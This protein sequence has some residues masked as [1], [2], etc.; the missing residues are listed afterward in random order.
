MQHQ[1]NFLNESFAQAQNRIKLLQGH[2]NYLKDSDEEKC[3]EPAAPTEQPS[4][5]PGYDSCRCNR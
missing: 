1:V 3:A 4:N 2:I 5:N